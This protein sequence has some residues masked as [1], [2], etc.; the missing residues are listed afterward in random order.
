LAEFDFTLPKLNT[1]APV[2]FECGQCEPPL[3]NF[4]DGSGTITNTTPLGTR[5]LIGGITDGDGWT[6][7]LINDGVE[8]VDLFRVDLDADAPTIAAGV[9][10]GATF[11]DPIGLISAEVNA[12]DLDIANFFS[13]DQRLNFDPNMMVELHFSVPTEVKGPS[14]TFF[15]TVSSI[16]LR[17]GESL[18]FHQPSEKLVITPVYT[19]RHNKFVND[20]RLM[21]NTAI[22]ETLD[23]VK[24]SG[25]IPD[26]A[27]D[28]V[29]TDLNFALLQLTPEL[30]DPQVVTG[31]DT[32][33]WSLGG[34]ED[35][36]GSDLTVKVIN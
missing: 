4:D 15:N 13:V 28:L 9:P 36:T 8:D 11:S 30:Y 31:T 10:L 17:V 26:L 2:G 32:T 7:P 23:Q 34:F 21:V 1:P 16:T 3:R 35:V 18:Q 14:D 6:L 5:I 27:A 29:G 24:L 20:T 22:Q 25:T 12:L 33:P 19:L